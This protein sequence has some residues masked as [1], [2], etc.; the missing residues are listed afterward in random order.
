M[1]NEG[2][3]QMRN[4]ETICGPIMP[5]MSAALL[6]RE[7]ACRNPAA[8]SI[9]GAVGAAAAVA[10]ADDAAVAA[11]ALAAAGAAA[12]AGVAAAGA[13]GA[14]AKAAGGAQQRFQSDG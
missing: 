10:V 2:S 14:A 8:A 7:R 11:A 4:G 1:L 3:A 6:C 9:V 13:A 5:R 12:A